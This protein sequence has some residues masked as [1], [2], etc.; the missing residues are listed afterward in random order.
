MHCIIIYDELKIKIDGEYTDAKKAK[1]FMWEGENPVAP[2]ESEAQKP[3]YSK[4]LSNYDEEQRSGKVPYVF[5]YVPSM[6]LKSPSL[7][8]SYNDFAIKHGSGLRKQTKGTVLLTYYRSGSS[9]LGQLFN[10]HPDVF[11]HFEPLFPYS[12]DCSSDS[13]AFKVNKSA[14][15][16]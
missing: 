5:D 16:F 2:V 11:Y 7:Q 8:K 1:F 10:Q 12:R 15:V 6:F 13:P 14:Y 3:N 4:F 9:F